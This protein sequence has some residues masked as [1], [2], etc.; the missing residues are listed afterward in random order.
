MADAVTGATVLHFDEIDWAGAGAAVKS[1]P[2]E[3]VEAART[4]G[5]GRS[6]WWWVRAAST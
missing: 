6:A 5:R 3:L 2:K 4:S 1:A